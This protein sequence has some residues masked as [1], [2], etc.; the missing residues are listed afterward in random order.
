MR[1]FTTVVISQVDRDKFGAYVK[2]M[3]NYV[4]TFEDK[5]KLIITKRP[6]IFGLFKESVVHYEYDGCAPKGTHCW[7]WGDSGRPKAVYTK[8]GRAAIELN[9]QIQEFDEL[10]M[11]QEVFGLYLSILTC[12]DELQLK[13]NTK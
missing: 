13:E 5:V 10:L 3:Q 8:R 12:Y 2:V 7:I 6:R 4:E 1:S 9:K 11:D